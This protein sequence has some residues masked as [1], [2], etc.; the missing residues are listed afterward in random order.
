MAG[1]SHRDMKGP[2]QFFGTRGGRSASRSVRRLRRSSSFT[3]TRCA[4][5]TFQRAEAPPEPSRFVG[6][7]AGPPSSASSS[8]HRCGSGSIRL[9]CDR[10]PS[11][12]ARARRKVAEIR[13]SVPH[14]A[15]TPALVSRSISTHSSISG[16]A[17][18]SRY[19]LSF[20]QRSTR[21]GD[22]RL[23]KRSARTL[24]AIG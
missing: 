15:S 12:N 14:G 2:R 10:T 3:S 8:N 18:N 7:S 5:T 22:G 1:S 16:D 23:R 17:C 6:V 13:L 11:P 24:Q 21:N 4:A 9:Y 19:P 20:A